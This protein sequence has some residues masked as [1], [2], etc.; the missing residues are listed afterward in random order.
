MF[1]LME[2]S[3]EATNKALEFLRKEVPDIAITTSESVHNLPYKDRYP[4][5]LDFYVTHYLN[6]YRTLLPSL[7]YHACEK[8][9]AKHLVYPKTNKLTAGYG[10]WHLIE[11]GTTL[12]NFQKIQL[13]YV[14]VR[15]PIIE[16]GGFRPASL[17][18]LRNK[19][20][21]LLHVVMMHDSRGKPQNHQ[22][23]VTLEL[24]K[25]LVYYKKN[26]SLV[27]KLNVDELMNLAENVAGQVN[28]KVS[29][30]DERVIALIKKRIEDDIDEAEE[31][32]IQ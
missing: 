27:N 14:Y 19:E 11:E 2:S 12:V 22:S 15:R 30:W 9:M 18:C 24:A 8:K 7:S 5:L 25:S 17:E 23:I 4:C 20:P 10:R 26:L 1:E 31:N 21:F 32:E 29:L 13:E 28:K 6:R 16:S 3:E